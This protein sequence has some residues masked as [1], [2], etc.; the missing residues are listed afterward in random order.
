ML[1]IRICNAAPANYRQKKDK[2]MARFLLS[3]RKSHGAIPGSLI[4]I[5]EAKM[6]Q[7]EIHLMLYDQESLTEKQ[8]ERPSE[9]PENIPEGTVLWINVYG[10]HDTE[11]VAAIGERFSIPPLELE[12]ILNT[13]QRP[14][15]IENPG[16]LTIFLKFLEFREETTHVA[17]EQLSVVVGENYVVTFQE[18][19]GQHFEPVRKRLRD[20]RGRI[21]KR[22]ADYLA[23]ALIDTIVDG[24]LQ[25][26]ENLGAKMEAMEEEVLHQTQRETL[27]KIYR[28]KTNVGFVLKSIR[29]LKEMMLFL[30]RTDLEV[31]HKKTSAY[32]KDL[33]DLSTQALEA[34]EFYYNMAQDYLNI[35]HTNVS[36]RTNEVMKVLTIFASIFIPLTFIAGVYGTNFDYL[37]ELHYKYSYFIML[38]GMVLMAGGMLVYFKRKGWL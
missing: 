36:N 11:M 33:N 32:L 30:N 25:T 38:G 37:P 10:L 27:E 1:L 9:I 22:G 26:I 17:G 2:K 21:R 6:E 15:I 29:P 3:R 12:D 16:N 35:Y 4:F 20:S 7:P 24:Y 8:I 14:K 28:L 23:Y 18:R 31:V 34:V 13:D 5:G 19:K